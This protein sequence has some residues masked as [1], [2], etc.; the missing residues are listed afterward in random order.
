[1]SNQRDFDTKE[2]VRVLRSA[3]ELALSHQ[4]EYTTLEH[5]MCVMLDE[6][7][8]QQILIDLQVD[9]EVV[10]R[11]LTELLED[12]SFLPKTF[13]SSQQPTETDT[14]RNVLQQS[15]AQVVFSSRKEAKP[16]D[17]LVG[18][19]QQDNSYAAHFLKEQ[20]LDSLR[21]KQYLAHG[22]GQM[23]AG[24]AQPN[25]QPGGPGGESGGM[26]KDITSKDEALAFLG[27]FTT[28]LNEVAEKG[29]IDP[30]I[31]REDEVETIVLMT[32]RRTK[33]NV[34]M[35]GEPGVGKTAIAEG[36]AVKI[37]NK[38]VPETIGDGVVYSLNIGD[39]LAGTKYRGDFEERMKLILKALSF[40]EK[41]IL[42][43]DEIHMIMGAGAGSNQGSMD[44]ANLLKPALAKG[45][46]R[47]IGSTTF[48][49]YRKHFEKDRALVR[50]FQKMD[51][52]E[53][54]VENCKLIMRGLRAAYEEFHGVTF[55]DEALDC[56]VELTAR[57]VQNR[58]L[59][60]KAIDAIDAAGAR[61]RIRPA[62]KKETT[63]VAE[64]I[65]FEVSRIAKI[66]A[67]T[68][69]NDEMTKLQKLD[70]DL[71]TVV[72]GQ[73]HAIDTVVDAIMVSRAGLREDNKPAG[74]FLFA[75]PTGVGKTEVAKQLSATLGVP[76][77]RFDMSEY[78]EKHSV[79]KLIGAPPGYVGHGDG[80]SGNGLLTN[81]IEN[82]PHCVLL[83][84]EIEKAHPDVFNVMLQVFDDGRLTNSNGK[85]VQFH[86][87]TIIM[88][89]NAGASDA[90]KHTLGFNGPATKVGAEDGVINRMFTPEFRN[91]LDAIVKFNPLKRENMLQVV[92]K[93]L[94]S[95]VEQ[96]GRQDIKI[97]V[98]PEAK[99]YLADKGYDA[100]MGARPLARLIT[101]DIKR[102]LS[103][104]IV[105]KQVTE[106]G[107]VKVN[108]IDGKIVVTA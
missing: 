70:T 8:I 18:I 72:F 10:Q 22:A 79:S 68:V 47:C 105:F 25:Q 71:K 101:S 1:M 89:S 76:L 45:N 65:Q 7:D 50:R 98:S 54:T 97:A 90:A 17:L 83:L 21:L 32:A 106:G 56:A 51:V 107:T 39:L 28:N 15:V 96:L 78:M 66:P 27:R 61:Q 9:H 19:I 63:I 74:V 60:D 52:L 88:A 59:P 42:F 62:D 4:H 85:T 57:Y 29:K 93:F 102:P 103:R 91:R 37:V 100:I 40:I 80:G 81:E 69:N 3:N 11:A 36:L 43:I 75:G 30:V 67:E 24:G 48:D 12:A 73:D 34:I 84:D 92:N 55:T 35:V 23:A 20:G 41:P 64:H 33:N 26:P 86:N 108:L 31:G 87:V 14:L 5:L 82:K 38:E 95:L 99:E 13:D 104:L 58:F 2:V 46:L 77:V 53:P 16:R 6:A 49:E 94:G 44:V